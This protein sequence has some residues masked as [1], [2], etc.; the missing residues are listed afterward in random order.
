MAYLIDL[1]VASFLWIFPAYV[2]NAAPVV[3]K[4]KMPLD[5]GKKLRDGN[6][7]FGPG[8]TIEGFV[9]GFIA[10][11]IIGYLIGRWEIGILLALGTVLG[12]LA[13][14]FIKRRMGIERGQQTWLL[15]QYDF[16]IGALLVASLLALPEIDVLMVILIL[17]PT[18]HLLTNYV[19]YKLKL[20][21][22]PW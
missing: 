18:L 8:K 15:D 16:L 10:G 9:G 20:K 19:A 2:A 12:D 22:V 7:L 1:I 5:F 3:L 21:E 13:G 11:S 6:R 4:G 14:S 17:T